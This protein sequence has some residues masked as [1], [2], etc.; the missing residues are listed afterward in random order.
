MATMI[1]KAARR[2]SPKVVVEYEVDPP[3]RSKAAFSAFKSWPTKNL[4]RLAEPVQRLDDR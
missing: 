2:S 1:C 3:A 4:R